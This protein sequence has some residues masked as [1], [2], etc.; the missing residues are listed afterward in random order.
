MDDRILNNFLEAGLLELNGNDA[1][2]DHITNAADQLATYIAEHPQTLPEFIYSAISTSTDIASDSARTKAREALKSVRRTYAS[3]SMDSID[4]VLRGVILDAIIQNTEENKQIKLAVTLLLSSCLPYIDLEAE[5]KVWQ[6]TLDKLMQEMEVEAENQW[7]VPASIQLPSAPEFSASKLR[8]QFGS[9]K[10]D[11]ESITAGLEKASCPTDTKGQ[12]T[13]GNTHWPNSGQ[14]WAQAFYPI[15]ADTISEALKQISKARS[16]NIDTDSFIEDLQ[17]GIENYMQTTAELLTKASHGVDL[18]SRLLWWKEAK[19]SPSTRVEYRSVS[20]NVLPAL[21]A[22]DYQQMLP[23]LSPASVIAFLRETVRS[24]TDASQKLALS[25]YISELSTSDTISR[26]RTGS[27]VKE[28][29]FRSLIDL[30]NSGSSEEEAVNNLTI[31]SAK[32]ILSPHDFATLIF[33]ELQALQV[34]KDIHPKE[35]EA[36]TVDDPEQEVLE[37]QE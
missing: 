1:W 10:I 17:R 28:G 14:A 18:R 3:V 13:G 9:L 2:F 12:P 37:P 16:A 19:I 26:F 34:I 5:A 24:L 22:F 11:E 7:S 4:T 30:I 15:A 6:S 35:A 27:P 21:M 36:D 29:A 20:P 25:D 8:T 23:A 33:L 32:K 31:F